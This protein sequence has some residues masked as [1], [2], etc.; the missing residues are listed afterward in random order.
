MFLEPA[1]CRQAAAPPCM[2][3]IYEAPKCNS[4]SCALRQIAE[5]L[6]KRIEL[7]EIEQFRV[8]IVL[9]QPALRRDPLAAA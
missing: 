5:T 8:W 9:S 1:T 2:D 3:S 4:N 6:R 7:P